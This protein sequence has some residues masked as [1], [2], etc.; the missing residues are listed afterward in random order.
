MVRGDAKGQLQ[1]SN[2]NMYIRKMHRLQLPYKGAKMYYSHTNTHKM[3]YFM[4]YIVYSWLDYA[5][6]D[7]DG[8]NETKLYLRFYISNKMAVAW[9]RALQY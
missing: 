9:R 7:D 2:I 1:R 3:L 6:V 8:E 5:R 4:I